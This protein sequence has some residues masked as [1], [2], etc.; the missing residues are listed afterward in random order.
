MSG[1]DTSTFKAHSI[2][3]A[4][5]TE[6]ARQ[7]FSISDILQFADWSQQ[8]TFIKFYYRPQF[9]TATGLAVLSSDTNVVL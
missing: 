1:I 2:R 9:N 4:V 7:G 5:T 6:V 3:G 8:N